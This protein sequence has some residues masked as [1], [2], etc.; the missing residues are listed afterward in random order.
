MACLPLGSSL[1][2]SKPGCHCRWRAHFPF[3]P[4][5]L[6]LTTLRRNLRTS[7]GGVAEEDGGACGR[8]GWPLAAGLG[9]LSLLPTLLAPWGIT[10]ILRGTSPLEKL[11]PGLQG[12]SS[13]KPPCLESST[14]W[15]HFWDSRHS[16]T[17]NPKVNEPHFLPSR[18]SRVGKVRHR[19]WTESQGHSCT[20]WVLRGSIPGRG[21]PEQRHRGQHGAKCLLVLQLLWVCFFWGL[22]PTST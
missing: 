9:P 3:L 1:Y 5:C 7:G 19:Q 2:F 22:I 13:Q 6:R 14:S 8:T 12:P 10:E 15:A 21:W 4:S 17:Q 20:Y 11:L 18:S 16:G